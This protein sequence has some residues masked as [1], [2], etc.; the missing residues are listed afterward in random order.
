MLSTTTP[1]TE[2][3]TVQSRIGIVAKSGAEAPLT[4]T[5][6]LLSTVLVPVLVPVAEADAAAS[7]PENIENG[8][9]ACFKA[10]I[11]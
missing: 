5:E 10:S 7:E 2:P 4:E 8:L 3:T 9:F 6:E 1:T 11:S